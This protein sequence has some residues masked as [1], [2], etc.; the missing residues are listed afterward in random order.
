[1]LS[2]AWNDPATAFSLHASHVMREAFGHLLSITNIFHFR[3]YIGFD[4][5]FGVLQRCR[6][7]QGYIAVERSVYFGGGGRGGSL[8]GKVGDLVFCKKIWYFN[9]LY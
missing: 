5:I 8:W 1:M 6:P 4:S 2:R 7:K 3:F 9:S